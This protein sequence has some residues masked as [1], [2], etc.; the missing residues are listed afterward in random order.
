MLTAHPNTGIPWFAAGMGQS[1]LIRA[2]GSN[3]SHNLAQ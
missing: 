3:G 2:P 1:A